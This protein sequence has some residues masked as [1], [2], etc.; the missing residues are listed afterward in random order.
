MRISWAGKNTVAT[1][2]STPTAA[3]SFTPIAKM[4]SMAFMFCLPQYCAASMVV[5]AARPL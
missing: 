1:K 2:N 5:P 3:A 4:C